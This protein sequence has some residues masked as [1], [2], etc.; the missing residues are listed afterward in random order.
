LEFHADGGQSFLET[1]PVASDVL[2]VAG[3]LA[4]FRHRSRVREQ[5][6]LLCRSRK[7]VYYVTGNHE[8]YKSLP[9]EVDSMIETIEK[10]LPVLRVLRPGRVETFE[11]R[12]ILGATLWFRDDPMNAMY[13]QQLNDFDLI[14]KFVPWV[15]EQNAAAVR[16]FEK[17]L[18]KDDIV[19]TH[20]L[21]SYKSVPLRFVES[22][23][24]RFFVC[25]LENLILE[26]QP[27]LWTHGHTHTPCDYF[28]D[29]CRVVANPLGYPRE[30]SNFTFNDKL[31]LSV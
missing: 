10:E 13:A 14:K 31:V 28:L 5:F 23:L 17:E 16:F 15:Y 24:N 9:R 12:R 19:V 6:D 4:L 22:S 1:L 8:Y 11:G 20:H 2:V 3:D 7:R 29:K 26:R 30:Q 18:Q 25:D 21:P 27:A